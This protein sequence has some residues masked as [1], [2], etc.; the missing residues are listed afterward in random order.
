MPSIQI[1]PKAEDDL[2]E[3]WMAIALDNPSAADRML[4]RIGAAIER[5]ARF[6]ESGAPREDIARGARMLVEGAYLVLYEIT[7]DDVTVVR[8][9]HGARDLR[10]L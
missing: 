2:G 3:I 4:K 6:P 7:A 1:S 5:L 9:V 10:R 8:V